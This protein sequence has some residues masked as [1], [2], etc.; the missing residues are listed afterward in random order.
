MLPD[1]PVNVRVILYD[2]TEVALDTVY[3]GIEDQV[4]TWCVVEPPPVEKI[5]EMKID[6][7]PGYTQVLIR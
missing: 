4:H 6:K 5:R 7:L 2:D 3:V 1:P